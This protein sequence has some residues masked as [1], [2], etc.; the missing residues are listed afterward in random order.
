LS[1]A[2]QTQVRKKEKNIPWAFTKV[3]YYCVWMI[4]RI[5]KDRLGVQPNG[6][7][8]RGYTTKQTRKERTNKQTNKQTSNQINKQTNKQTNKQATK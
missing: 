4:W 8:I 2:L 7:T 5:K 1:K 3:I 6:L